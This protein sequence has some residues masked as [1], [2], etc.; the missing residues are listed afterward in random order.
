[1]GTAVAASQDFW[2]S[3]RVV[4]GIWPGNILAIGT[5]APLEW[6]WP[7][8]AMSVEN[9]AVALSVS[10]YE[11]YPELGYTTASHLRFN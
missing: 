6:V 11:M 3:R 4:P 5:R 10:M 9:G 2:P 8:A 1:M 7:V